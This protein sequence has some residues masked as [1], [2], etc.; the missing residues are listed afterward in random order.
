MSSKSITTMTEGPAIEELTRRLAECPQAFLGEPVQKNGAGDVFI[1]AVV[2][3]LLSSMGGPPLTQNQV[4][5]LSYSQQSRVGQE[6]NRLRVILVACWLGDHPFFQGSADPEIFLQWLTEGLDSLAKLV[7]AE[8]L[9]SDSERR[10]ELARMALAA[11]GSRPL[12]EDKKESKDRLDAL[13]TV[14]RAAV[15][16]HSQAAQERA[17]KLRRELAEKERARRAASTYNHE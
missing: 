3:D 12:G 15:V 11:V 10:E 4:D 5:S 1:P 6:R 7:S 16:K 13:S 2:S 14:K 17:R 9:I 8:K